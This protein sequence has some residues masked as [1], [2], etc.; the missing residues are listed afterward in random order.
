[1]SQP[2]A[3]LLR[4]ASQGGVELGRRGASPPARCCAARAGTARGHRARRGT[5]GCSK[6]PPGVARVRRTCRLLGNEVAVDPDVSPLA[7]KDGNRG[8][9]L[10]FLSARPAVPAAEGFAQRAVPC[11]APSARGLG[12][13]PPQDLALCVPFPRLL[14]PLPEQRLVPGA[15]AR[16]AMGD[17]GQGAAR[18]PGTAKGHPGK[19]ARA[20]QP[21]R[22]ISPSGKRR[23]SRSPA[24]IQQPLKFPTALRSPV[25]VILLRAQSG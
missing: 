14:A 16:Q 25:S 3:R 13:F 23:P 9:A 18:S 17:D 10:V 1:M 8:V 20:P 6:V 2:G 22:N 15:V 21:H 24:G 12:S 4:W 11:F 19:A 7:L 5:S